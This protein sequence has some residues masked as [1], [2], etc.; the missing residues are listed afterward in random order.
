MTTRVSPVI[1]FINNFSTAGRKVNKVVQ[2]TELK[3]GEVFYQRRLSKGAIALQKEGAKK[4]LTENTFIIFK[5]DGQECVKHSFS[6]KDMLSGI[7]RWF[8]ADRSDYSTYGQN[9]YTRQLQKTFNTYSGKLEEKALRTVSPD[10]GVL[11]NV[12]SKNVRKSVFPSTAIGKNLHPA[13]YEKTILPNGD[14][15]YIE[16]YLK[17]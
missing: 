3:P 12:L 10:D 9:I 5:R 14:I 1:R 15:N 6:L 2:S 13:V 11:I 4:A 7:H 16:K 8:S 17:P